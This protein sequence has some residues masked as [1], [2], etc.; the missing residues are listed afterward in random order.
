[1]TE[2]ARALD[3]DEFLDRAFERALAL[4]EAGSIPTVGELLQGREDLRSEVEELVRVAELV[5]LVSWSKTRGGPFRPGPGGQ[6]RT[7]P[8]PG[9]LPR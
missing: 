8:T 5:M 6:P 7:P 1:M 3:A 4:L 9:E 2:D